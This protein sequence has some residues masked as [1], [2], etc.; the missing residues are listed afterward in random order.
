MELWHHVV[1]FD[2]RV[3]QLQTM[4][5]ESLD[6]TVGINRVFL[7]RRNQPQLVSI[8]KKLAPVFTA[9]KVRESFMRNF[10]D[11]IDNTNR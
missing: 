10:V 3:P 1:M 2:N 11:S 4:K 5:S 6:Y 7:Y 9:P 8:S